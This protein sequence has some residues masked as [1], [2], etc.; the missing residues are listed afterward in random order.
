VQ[1][2]HGDEE[3]LEQLQEIIMKE[4]EEVEKRS[5]RGHSGEEAKGMADSGISAFEKIFG[6]FRK[7]TEVDDKTK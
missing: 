7:K 1:W 4:E 5:S 6:S 3:R 2:T